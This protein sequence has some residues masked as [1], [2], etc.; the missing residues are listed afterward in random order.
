MKSAENKTCITRL[1]FCSKTAFYINLAM[2]TSFVAFLNKHGIACA[3]DCDM[4]LYAL[5]KQEPVAIAVNPYSP[6]PWKSIINAYLCRGNI[7]LPTHF[8]DYVNDFAQYLPSVES[9][10][11]W[12]G[13]TAEETQVIFLGFGTNDLFPSAISADVLLNK[14]SNILHCQIDEECHINHD[15]TSEH[16]A[17][18]EFEDLLPAL[19][20]VNNSAMESLISLCNKQKDNF[21]EYKTRM[22]TALKKVNCDVSLD[23]LPFDPVPSFSEL[24]DKMIVEQQNQLNNVIDF[25]NMEDM[26]KAVETIIDANG[27]LEHLKNGD[28]GDPRSTKELAVITRTEGLV[29]IKHCLQGL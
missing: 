23:D 18:D 2:K 27:Q 8:S 5:S 7:P 28:I 10:M 21:M 22:E 1:Q 4:T 14:A 3:S 20:G 15:T 26:V 19:Y 11:K 17:F 9:K 12:A 29:W 24:T 6:I 16:F 13:L 25:F